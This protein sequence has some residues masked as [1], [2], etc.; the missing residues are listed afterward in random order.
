MLETKEQKQVFAGA[1]VLIVILGI[2]SLVSRPNFQQQTIDYAQLQQKN[3]QEQSANDA[4]L[5]SLGTSEAAQEEAV[6]E[7]LPESEVEA[8][9]VSE[10]KSDQP[11]V[12]PT[13]ADSQIKISSASGKT[14]L[15]NY[16][17]QASPLLDPLKAATD[18]AAEDIYNQQG[19]QNRI[20]SLLADVNTAVSGLEKVSTPKEAVDFQKQLILSLQAYAGMIQVSQPYM[21]GQTQEP[22]PDMYK[23]YAIISKTAA[24]AGADFTQLN[25][26]YNL[27]GDQATSANNLVSW[28]LPTAHAQ[29]LTTDVWAKA[30]YVLEEAA[31]RAISQFMLSFLDK[32]ANKIEQTYRISNFLY[33]SDALVSGQYVDDYLNKYVT[34]PLDRELAKNFIPQVTCGNIK[35]NNQTFQAK[36]DQY[37]GF[38]PTTLDPND[39]DY[40][41]KMAKVGNFMSSAEG[42]NLYYQGI[43]TQAQSS[44]QQAVNNEILS[45]GLK[46]GRDATGSIIT[47]TT[48]TS[49]SLAAVLNRYM[50]EGSDSSMFVTT[51]QMAEQIVQ[52]F[53]TSFILKGVVLAE[54][55][56]CIAVP[57]LQLVTTALP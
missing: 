1:I 53:L 35:N 22:W 29:I 39:P 54:Q 28:L 45:P 4:Y 42:W 48:V 26:K 14:A 43:A 49:G 10:L 27:L 21:S 52:S 57:Q 25:N 50:T 38:D 55:K 12:L 13:L 5:A 7:L 47:P 17:G 2:V 32:L 56:A 36:A 51:Q 34:D 24:A 37:L 31:S 15:Q 33:Y 9:V 11:I 19:D 16:I 30:Q 8:A 6:K 3:R 44:A 40:Y 41:S 46:T 20:N 18:A 23:N